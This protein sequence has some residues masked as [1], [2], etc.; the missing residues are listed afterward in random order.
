MSFSTF[1]SPPPLPPPPRIPGKSPARNAAAT[2]IPNMLRSDSTATCNP[3]HNTAAL[4]PSPPKRKPSL[5]S[6]SP[7]TPLIPSFNVATSRPGGLPT[8]PVPPS[9]QTQNTSQ[10]QYITT[11]QRATS[12]TS[13]PDSPTSRAMMKRLL[14]RPAAPAPYSGSES[15]GRSVGGLKRAATVAGSGDGA[16]RRVNEERRHAAAMTSEQ[17]IL[18]TGNACSGNDSDAGVVSATSGRRNL[19][20][21]ASIPPSERR[22][23]GKPEEKQ[24]KLLRRKPSASR[25]TSPSSSPSRTSNPAVGSSN[26]NTTIKRSLSAAALTLAPRQSLAPS[27]KPP[28]LTPASALVEAYRAQEQSERASPKSHH[29]ST[30]LSSSDPEYLPDDDPATP[31][32][33]IFGSSSDRV[34]PVDSF[35]ARIGWSDQG[36]LEGIKRSATVK[37]TSSAGGGLRTLTRK[38][39]GRWKKAQHA[40][41]EEKGR[42]RPRPSLQNS[43]GGGGRKSDV[44]VRTRTRT[45]S[46]STEGLVLDA[47]VKH[48]SPLKTLSGKV[49]DEERGRRPA[50]RPSSSEN[51]PPV[52][53]EGGGNKL[54][55]LMKRISTGALRDKYRAEY[56]ETPA[57]PPLP[58]LIPGS[59]FAS[60]S[61]LALDAGKNRALARLLPSASSSRSS[62]V[63]GEST[64]SRVR[65]APALKTSGSPSRQQGQAQGSGTT[66][67]SSPVSSSDKSVQYAH[68]STSSF[69]VVDVQVEQAVP[70][71][72]SLVDTLRK[73]SRK[74]QQGVNGVGKH[75]VHPSQLCKNS[76]LTTPPPSCRAKRSLNHLSLRQPPRPRTA[77]SEDWMIVQSPGVELP[78]LPFPPRRGMTTL[79][80]SSAALAQDDSPAPAPARDDIDARKK[81]E[82][83]EEEERASGNGRE[84]P[85]L[86]EFLISGAINTFRPRKSGDSV[87]LKPPPLSVPVVPSAGSSTSPGRSASSPMRSTSSPTSPSS[88]SPTSPKSPSH[89]TRKSESHTHRKSEGGLSILTIRPGRRSSSYDLSTTAT[90]VHGEG[91]MG[92]L[93]PPPATAARSPAGATRS[94]PGAA[95]SPTSSKKSPAS[96]SLAAKT[97]TPASTTNRSTSTRS[98]TSSTPSRHHALTEQEKAQRWDDLLERSA[99]A[100]GTLHL[101]GDWDVTL[102]SDLLRYSSTPS[103]VEM[104]G[105]GVLG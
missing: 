83:D 81:K 39:S 91:S 96:N 73:N 28:S 37:S 24:R 56:H 8:T 48:P 78:S 12:T 86:P 22:N 16:E 18:M 64:R 59:A 102:Q 74:Q 40:G 43:S 25:V 32:Y 90:V 51:P 15:E 97:P 69:G 7:P 57:P 34:I 35:E 65:T 105:V 85:L 67:S 5:A 29:P 33:T 66:R 19:Q 55:R 13:S 47:V 46:L 27:P 53:S 52:P 89:H 94:P 75:I 42:I 84:S 70:P 80:V 41:E 92:S 63:G 61:P 99:R 104:A 2:P 45:R 77:D 82:R 36:Y 30:P 1:A 26:T 68:S 50:R 60:S 6:P 79:V 58:L 100:G 49:N 44:G 17:R 93:N 71:V 72:P 54:W 38:V 21:I 23:S 11:F 14:A 62:S 76:P 20:E 98:S 10:S 95:K 31:Y 101:A 87:A 88:R 103:E 9:T 3:P 4:T